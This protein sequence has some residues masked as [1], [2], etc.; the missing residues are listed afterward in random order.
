MIIRDDKDIVNDHE[1]SNEQE[2]TPLVGV[3]R[4]SITQP[5]QVDM[6]VA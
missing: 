5:V 4:E 6:F 3:S 1:S 2:D